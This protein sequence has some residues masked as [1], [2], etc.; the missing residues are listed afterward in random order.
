MRHFLYSTELF[1]LE[2]IFLFIH[3]FLNTWILGG[4]H[5]VPH[6]L[7]IYAENLDERGQINFCESYLTDQYIHRRELWVVS[8]KNPSSVEFENKKIFSNFIF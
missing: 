1:A 8:F 7:D 5:S 2:A 6:L 4:F 3:I